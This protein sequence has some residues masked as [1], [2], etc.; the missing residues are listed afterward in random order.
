MKSLVFSDKMMLPTIPTDL[1]LIVRDYLLGYTNEECGDD[2]IQKFIRQ[3]SE[4]SWRNF[5][6]VSN[7]TTWRNIRKETMIWSLNQVAS[8]KYFLDLEFRKYIHESI[9]HSS[10][11]VVCRV[12]NNMVSIPFLFDGIAMSGIGSISIEQYS[13]REFPSFLDLRTLSIWNCY[14]LEELGSFPELRRLQ[15][16]NCSRVG[17][18]GRMNN[19]ID[20][21]LEYVPAELVSQFPLD[22]IENLTLGIEDGSLIILPRL[23]SIKELSLR[24][25]PYHMQGVLP[26][27]A[28]PNFVGLTKLHLEYFSSVNLS[29]LVGLKQLSLM[30]VPSSQIFGK[31]DIYP[32][33]K[34]FSYLSGTDP[35]EELDHCYSR[36]K[37]VTDFTLHVNKNRSRFV[38]PEDSKIKCL[39]ISVKNIPLDFAQENRFYWNIR[40][41][42]CDIQSYSMFSN[43]QK[44]VLIEPTGTTDITPL[45]NIPYLHLEGLPIL[46]DLSCLGKQRFLDI[47]RC[48]GLSNE[49]V[50]NFGNVF[51]LSIRDCVGVT[52]IVGLA[53]NSKIYLHGCDLLQRVDLRGND[54]ISVS[55]LKCNDLNDFSASGRI[56]YLEFLRSTPWEKSMFA[57]NYDYLNGEKQS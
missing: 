29:G 49:T 4:R 38:L 24:M 18:V 45:R 40:L 23:K 26:F 31:E 50:R 11:Q 42:F 14:H 16:V 34:S 17:T 27:S 47:Y 9:I 51:H 21:Y 19:L 48:S 57:F 7:H 8:R 44:L 12:V 10:K 32:Q 3:E 33:L 37:N 39:D 53:N 36:L 52:E 15:L 22:Q 2:F 30:G 35:G 41:A 13:L 5:L 28:A 20:L 55:V 54:Y 6:S 56:Y 46:T 25:H 43:V 1:L